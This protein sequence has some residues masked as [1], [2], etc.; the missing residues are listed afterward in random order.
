M[1]T[2]D[3]T[4]SSDY[5][6]TGHARENILVP[7]NKWATRHSRTS[8]EWLIADFKGQDYTIN[9]LG[10]LPRQDGYY[11]QVPLTVDVYVPA[12]DNEDEWVEIWSTEFERPENDHEPE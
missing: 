6:T 4:T 2:V 5:D 9:G 10:F 7:E 12:E 1:N 11:H 8:D 3:L